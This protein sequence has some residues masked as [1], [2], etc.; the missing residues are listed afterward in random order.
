MPTLITICI[1]F[2]KIWILTFLAKVKNMKLRWGQAF[3]NT[4][5][6]RSELL[7]DNRPRAWTNADISIDS[8]KS[9]RMKR[10][11]LS[12]VLLLQSLP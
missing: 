5:T 12:Q 11:G 9:G 6:G 10:L 1:E 8:M 2:E 4:E 3:V 7:L